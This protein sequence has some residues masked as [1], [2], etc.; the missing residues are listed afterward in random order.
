MVWILLLYRALAVRY[1][2][3]ALYFPFSSEE[4]IPVWK[5]LDSTCFFHRWYSF[6]LFTII[7]YDLLAI[8]GNQEN[9]LGNGSS[10]VKCVQIKVFFFCLFLLFLLQYVWNWLSVDDMPLTFQVNDNLFRFR[11]DKHKRV[12]LT[13]ERIHLWNMNSCKF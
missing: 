9:T 2:R 1:T 3:E 13:E 12:E 7:L 4:T 8:Y 5:I 11:Y 10:C 6:F